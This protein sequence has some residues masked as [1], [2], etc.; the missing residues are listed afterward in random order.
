VGGVFVYASL[1]KLADPAGFAVAVSHYHLVPLP[2]LH[3]FAVV[4]PMVELVAGAALVLGFRLRG[5]AL[6]TGAMTVVFTAAIASALARHL[7][8]SCGCFNTDGG[9]AV[10]ASLLLRDA[11]LLAACLPPLL[12][13]DAGPALDGLRRPRAKK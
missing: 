1:G 11:L 6:L 12:L 7:D 13:R 8:I 10:G 3:A 2:L 4:L 5:A 9:H